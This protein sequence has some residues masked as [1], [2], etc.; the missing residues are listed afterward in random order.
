MKLKTLIRYPIDIRRARR[1]LR[2]RAAAVPTLIERPIALDLRTDAMLFDC[3]RH[4]ASLAHHACGA[5]SPFLVRC[6]PLLLAGIARKIHGG[7]MLAESHACWIPR[8]APLPENA[9]VLCDYEPDHGSG[10]I[11]MLIGRD[12]DRE[13]AVM[14]YPM[15]PA[16]L[17]QLEQTDLVRLR[18]SPKR[19]AIFFAGNQKPRY[20][21]AKM[22]KN[23]GVLSRLEILGT[24]AERFPSRIATSMETANDRSIVISD[25]R[26]E[27]IAAAD[28]L[29]SLA[30]SR[31]FVCCPGSSQPMCH[32]LVEAMS[33]GTIPILEYGDRVTP[34]LRDG[35]NAIC[36][37]AKAGLVDAIDRIDRLSSVQVTRLSQ[38][39]ADF[40]DEHLCGTKFMARLRDGE[41][42]TSSRCLCMP[43]HERNFYQSSC[44]AAA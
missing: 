42:D 44:L 21:D 14:P 18:K 36:F 16:T 12:I 37:E 23:F 13:L 17:R 1:L 15:H 5:G 29:P 10:F 31:F 9:L 41:L 2:E 33:V 32:N 28:W 22:Q 43:F 8:D 30:R 7:E 25:S 38:N 20:G 11:Q 40:Y 3:G 6:S 19:S 4:F 26:V 34:R 39:V 35:E 24:L 27:S